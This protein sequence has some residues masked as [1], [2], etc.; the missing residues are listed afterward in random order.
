[1]ALEDIPSI[2][3]GPRGQL[4]TWSGVFIPLSNLSVPSAQRFFFLFINH[5]VE[6]I[7][8]R[9]TGMGFYCWEGDCIGGWSR[10]ES[11]R[12]FLKKERVKMRGNLGFRLET[13][14]KIHP[15]FAA[16]ACVISQQTE[17]ADLVYR[18]TDYM[19]KDSNLCLQCWC[20]LQWF[21]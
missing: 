18:A 15:R 16:L 1:M 20:L 4:N 14:R 19:F 8:H 2:T 9:H 17:R 11:A 10:N 12:L 3:E 5:W 13:F 6:A 21:G 7:A